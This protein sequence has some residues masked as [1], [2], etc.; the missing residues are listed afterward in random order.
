MTST[1]VVCLSVYSNVNFFIS[2]VATHWPSHTSS[3]MLHQPVRGPT[4]VK[5]LKMPPDVEN[6]DSIASTRQQE[7]H[8]RTS[9]VSSSSTN[10][11]REFDP[12]SDGWQFLRADPTGY[13]GMLWIHP[14]LYMS[15]L[16]SHHS[17]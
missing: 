15:I 4:S 10:T 9:E 1:V 3:P 16:S 2:L 5:P 6:P 12:L 11:R 7:R 14:V 13:M 17:C 8:L